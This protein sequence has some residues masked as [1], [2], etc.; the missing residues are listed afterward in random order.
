MKCS[1]KYSTFFYN[2]LA[3]VED[4]LSQFSETAFSRFKD[5]L[6]DR[7]ERAKDMPMMYA[8][9]PYAPE[10]RHIVI[11]KYVVFYRFQ[12]DENTIYMH[13]LLHGAQNIPD[14]L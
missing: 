7:I 2:D 11:N 5:M 4:Y 8:A 1:V 13:R 12:E 6:Y 9:Y 10:Y 14:Y 3:A